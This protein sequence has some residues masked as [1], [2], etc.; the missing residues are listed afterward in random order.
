ML[1]TFR[2]TY[3]LLRRQR[4]LV[5]IRCEILVHIQLVHNQHYAGFFNE[6][7]EPR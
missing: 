6:Q 5:R 7:I 3:Y 2:P 1:E 4:T